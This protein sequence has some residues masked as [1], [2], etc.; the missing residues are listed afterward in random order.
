MSP[1][2]KPA[3]HVLQEV[4]L[5]AAQP[6]RAH[7][8]FDPCA[9]DTKGLR[10]THAV[11]LRT[12]RGSS[13][14]DFVHICKTRQFWVASCSRSHTLASS[15]GDS[16]GFVRRVVAGRTLV[17]VQHLRGHDRVWAGAGLVPAA[18]AGAH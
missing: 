12:G 10:T 2:T 6:R 14:R 16:N 3:V 5:L 11:A 7:E 9:P 8:A 17:G 15:L 4:T 13:T 18:A 1:A